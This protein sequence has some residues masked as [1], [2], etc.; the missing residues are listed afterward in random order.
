M[1]LRLRLIFFSREPDTTTKLPM[2]TFLAILAAIIV[3]VVIFA[4]EKLPSVFRD[5]VRPDIEREQQ[6][7]AEASGAPTP[8]P[9]PADYRTLAENLS[10]D[11]K[12]SADEY[13]DNKSITEITAEGHQAVMALRGIQSSDRDITY[14]AE[15]AE[16]AYA[17]AI[18]RFA[19]LNALPKP[20]GSG[21]LFVSSFIDGL[22]GDIFGGY[23]RGKDAE[24]KQNAMNVEVQ[25]LVAAYEK[26]D[27]AQQLL[28]KVAEK[29]SA[30][31]GDNNDRIVVDFDESWG[32]RKP[33]DWLLIS[34][35]GA[36]LQDCTL[37]VQ[38]TGEQGQV[39]KNVHFIK[40]WP[41]NTWMYA[42]YQPGQEILGRRVFNMSVR[43]VQ[44][45]DVT[46]YSPQFATAIDYVYQGAMKDKKIAEKYKD[47]KLSGRYRPFEAGRIFGDTER[48][49]YFTLDGVPFIGKCGVDVTFRNGSQRKGWH[50][51]F[52][53]WKK[54]EEKTFD[55]QKSQLMFD[56]TYIDVAISFP[57][58]GYKHE[59]SLNVRN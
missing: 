22:F 2:K 51:E 52:D 41:S 6:G 34:N 44:R 23:A 21:E 30:P 26:A 8:K 40:N 31:L 59:S 53:G 14:I 10:L 56:P 16:A 38:L 18:S 39:R 7:R 35:T 50:W 47:L 24:E 15:Q 5:L 11:I 54:G 17:E 3:A 55:T 57:G 13:R 20:P 1:R 42:R 36:A 37:V 28:P 29:Y 58:T 45:I 27:A 19:R 9:L 32:W 25:G 48:G 49:A 4:P 12:S 43:N 33:N 46:V